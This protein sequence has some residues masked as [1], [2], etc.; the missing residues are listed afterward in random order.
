MAWAQQLLS[1]LIACET[2]PSVPPVIRRANGGAA[3]RKQLLV[4]FLKRFLLEYNC[5][6]MV[7]YFLL[8]S[9]VNQPYVY[10]YPLFF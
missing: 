1:L 7:C 5:F 6:T 9:K 4:P 3:N 10:I 8:Y 2:C